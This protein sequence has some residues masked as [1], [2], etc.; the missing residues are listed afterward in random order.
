MWGH[1]TTNSLQR[2]ANDH[3][4]SEC[5]LK[6][7]DT[8]KCAN[9][10]G[11]HT[12]NNAKCHVYKKIIENKQS[13]VRKNKSVVPKYIPVPIPTTN[14]WETREK[15][16]SQRQKV[17]DQLKIT[18]YSDYNNCGELS[19]FTKLSNELKTLNS[20]INVNKFLLAIRNLNKK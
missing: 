15:S 17:P 18:E 8:P 10:G 16:A 14:V 2:C 4:T 5:P 1:S 6:I 19:E 20:V 9:C 12:A 11:Q 13:L 7:D 3:L